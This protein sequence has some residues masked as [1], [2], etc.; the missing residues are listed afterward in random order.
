M[1][2]TCAVLIGCSACALPTV[3]SISSLDSTLL[4]WYGPGGCA[5]WGMSA[6]PT[7]ALVQCFCLQTLRFCWHI[8]VWQCSKACLTCTFCC[9]GCE[10][11]PG[12]GLLQDHMLP[13]EYVSAMRKSMLD[14]CPVASYAQV[15]RTVTEDLGRPPEDLFASFEQRPIASASLAQ[16]CNTVLLHRSCPQA[17]SRGC[18]E[19]SW[20]KD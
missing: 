8:T 1:A 16:V 14:K 12:Q 7:Q 17:S 9:P 10:S 6:A 20:A 11:S 19:V 13:A 4:S 3:E 5:A 2:A 15:A 18:P